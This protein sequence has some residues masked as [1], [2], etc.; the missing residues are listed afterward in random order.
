LALAQRVDYQASK[1][2]SGKGEAYAYDRG[3]LTRFGAT[4]RENLF[5]GAGWKK[6]LQ[7]ATRA[8]GIET[9]DALNRQ[10][11]AATVAGAHYQDN[12]RYEKVKDGPDKDYFKSAGGKYWTDP[13][14]N[15]IKAFT[16]GQLAYQQ[17]LQSM[18]AETARSVADTAA[19]K[20]ALEEMAKPYSGMAKEQLWSM[21]KGTADSNKIKGMAMALANGG[22]FENDEMFNKAKNL[23]LS[24]QNLN[25]TSA[26]MEAAEKKQAAL[27]YDTEDPDQKKALSERIK[28]GKV[29]WEEQNL[30]TFNMEKPEDR[31]KVA[32]F[33]DVL[34]DSL[35]KERL[36]AGLVAIDKGDPKV[37]EKWAVGF[38]TLADMKEI[39]SNKKK[40][41][42]DRHLDDMAKLG[43]D[44]D[45]EEKRTA[46]QKAINELEGEKAKIDS[47]VMDL[48]GG[49]MALDLDGDAMK[50]FT[51]ENGIFDSDMF[52]KYAAKSSVKQLSQINSDSIANSPEA[53][54]ALA[55]AVTF[56]KLKGLQKSGNN[57]GLVKTIA[58]SMAAN[59]HPEADKIPYTIANNIK[60][61]LNAS[62]INK[63]IQTFM[64]KNGLAGFNN[65][66]KLNEVSANLKAGGL[67]GVDEKAVT[68]ALKKYFNT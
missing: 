55:Q 11:A 2:L 50:S 19:D 4:A 48:R 56:E 52:E 20:A 22:G 35:K 33:L 23:F 51:N 16:S 42:I 13:S 21:M 31:K 37:A 1:K 54:L 41:E 25:Q 10:K 49:R 62:S 29:K 26:F 28:K 24:G 18:K 40:A 57:P 63:I 60:V 46:H 65:L 66:K 45:S 38:G 27:V 12:V 64:G 59:N 39:E 58:E 36:T 15:R 7:K 6:N 32:Q 61:D 30:S 47:T 9:N 14:G 3:A 34:I 17:G 68:S 53:K 44:P 8:M 5:T 67:K 43:S